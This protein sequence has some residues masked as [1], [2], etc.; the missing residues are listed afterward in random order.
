MLTPT[1]KQCV[2]VGA[3]ALSLAATLAVGLAGCERPGGAATRDQAKTKKKAAPVVQVA[4][5]IE[6]K[7]QDHEEFTGRTEAKQTVEVRAHVTGYLDKIQFNDGD[8]VA[9]GDVLFEIDPRQYQ[10]ELNRA[11]ATLSQAESKEKRTELVYRRTASLFAKNARSREELDMAE[12]DYAEARASVGVASAIRDLAELNRNFTRVTAPITGRISRRMVDIGNLVKAD[13]TILT[14]IV[15]ISELYVYFDVDDRTVLAIRRLIREGKFT[16]ISEGDVPVE[17]ALV[18]Q[19]EF[20]TPGRVDFFES[21]LDANTGTLRVRAVIDNP[22]IRSRGLRSLSPGLF[23]RVR[24]P[25]GAP[26]SA[27]TIPESALNSDQGKKYIFVFRPK[28]VESGVVPDAKATD[29]SYRPGT[30]QVLREREERGEGASGTLV[31]GPLRDGRR[32][33]K[34]GLGPDDEVV[35]EGVQS[36]RDGVEVRAMVPKEAPV[37]EGAVGQGGRP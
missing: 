27:L 7:V 1:T 18:D 14:T 37:A 25:M 21:K 5:P 8:E 31:L 3:F 30:I 10:A 20:D 34:A 17:V 23:V 24:L 26:Y 19:R 6:A 22:T 12:D 13:D 11:G 2:H 35:V 29:A 9:E 28:A 4:R 36:L 16:S 33:I 32:V 15:N